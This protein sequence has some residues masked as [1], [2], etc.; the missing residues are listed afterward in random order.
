MATAAALAA[1]DDPVAL[2]D[3]RRLAF[4]RRIFAGFLAKHVRALRIAPW[5][6]P[7][8]PPPGA[9]LV[10]LANHPSWW[11]GVAFMLLSADLFPGRRMFIPMDAEA[12]AKYAFFR[13]IGCFPVAP[14]ARGAAAFLRTA[15]HVLA[16]DPSHML[17]MNAPGRFQDARERPVAVAAGVTR[18]PDMAPTATVLPLALE[19]TFWGERKPEMLAA[20]GPPVPDLATLPRPAREAAIRDA[21]TATMDRLAADALSRDPARL[22]ALRQGREGM[23]GAYDLYRRARAALRGERYDARHEAR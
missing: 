13:R 8:E 6:R 7:A 16:S 2:F 18:L 23:G 20:F 14:G 21:L 1:E 9:P 3:A 10:V 22:P 19:M 15:R 17:W 5:G 11:D 4:F 12:L